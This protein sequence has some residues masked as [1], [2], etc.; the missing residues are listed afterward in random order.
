MRKVPLFPRNFRGRIYERAGLKIREFAGASLEDP[1]DPFALAEFVKIHVV[2]LSS[3]RGL[4]TGIRNRLNTRFRSQWSAVTV[5]LPDGW[6]VCILNPTHTTERKR[7]T[8]MEEI[9]HVVLGHEPTRIIT[10]SNGV[11]YREFNPANEEAAYGVGAAALVPYAPLVIGLMDGQNPDSIARH[12]GVSSPL[13]LYRIKIT[14]LWSLYK[15][16]YSA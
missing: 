15:S 7:A 5:G 12:Y 13:V 4:P 1:L 9:S 11:G 10:G 6:Q 16:K 3:I 2:Y 8:L 14:M